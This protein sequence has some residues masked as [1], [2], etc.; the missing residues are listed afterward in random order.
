MREA[1]VVRLFE[2]VREDGTVEWVPGDLSTDDSW[3][4]DQ[5]DDDGSGHEEAIGAPEQQN[6]RQMAREPMASGHLRRLEPGT[7]TR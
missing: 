3:G 7:R 5:S 4:L 6:G 1:Q 2:F